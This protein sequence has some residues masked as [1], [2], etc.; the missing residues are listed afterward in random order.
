MTHGWGRRL[1]WGFMG[2]GCGSIRSLRSL[3]G[4]LRGAMKVLVRVLERSPG[5]RLGQ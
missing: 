4:E 1:C 2:R 3:K 5:E